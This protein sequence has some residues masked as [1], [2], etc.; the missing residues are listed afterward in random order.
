MEENGEEEEK[1]EE[2]SRHF[3]RLATISS[4][5]RGSGTFGKAHFSHPEVATGI[6]GLC[7]IDGEM[8]TREVRL[9]AQSCTVKKRTEWRFG[10]F[11]ELQASLL[12]FHG[13]ATLLPLWS[14]NSTPLSIAVDHEAG[15]ECCLQVII[16]CKVRELSLQP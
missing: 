12:R 7:F 10:R 8:K 15:Q 14:S 5:C 13:L 9:L 1:G 2:E 11:G 16:M 4:F 3:D 6:G